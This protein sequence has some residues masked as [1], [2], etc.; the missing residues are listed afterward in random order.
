[1]LVDD[2]A[3]QG[4]TVILRH[5]AALAHLAVRDESEDLAGRAV[6]RQRDVSE[7]IDIDDL[8]REQ[9]DGVGAVACDQHEGSARVGAELGE[10]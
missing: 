5:E 6:D 4:S 2:D 10:S 9:L 3:A 1:M 8:S 7:E